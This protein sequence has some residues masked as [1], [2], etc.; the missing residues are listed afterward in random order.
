MIGPESKLAYDKA[1]ALLKAGEYEKALAVVMLPSDRE[2]IE[3]RIA[4]AKQA[5]GANTT[6]ENK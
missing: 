2:I 6:K 4:A 3:R 1:N 5:A